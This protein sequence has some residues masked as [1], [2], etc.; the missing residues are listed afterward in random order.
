MLYLLDYIPATNNYI[1][2]IYIV[3][4]EEK[5]KFDFEMNSMFKTFENKINEQKKLYE[6]QVAQQ[7]IEY[8]Q[9]LSK[10]YEDQ[11]TKVEKIKLAQNAYNQTRRSNL[12]AIR[13]NRPATTDMTQFN[14]MVES[15]LKKYDPKKSIDNPPDLFQ[16][17]QQKQN[18]LKTKFIKKIEKIITLNPQNDDNNNDYKDVND[19]YKEDNHIIATC[20]RCSGAITAIDFE[21]N[22]S[23]SHTGNGQFEHISC[24]ASKNR[25]YIQRF[26]SSISQYSLDATG[27]CTINA[28]E[29]AIQLQM[30]RKPSIELVDEIVNLAALYKQDKHTAVGDILPAVTRYNTNLVKVDWL[31]ITV[32][33]IP[34]IIDAMVKVL[35]NESSTTNSVSAVLTKPPETIFIHMIKKGN[36]YIYDSHPRPQLNGSHFLIFNNR[37][38]VE[39][40]LQSMWP[41]QRL[42]AGFDD[43]RSQL[44]N[45][46]DVTLLQ[47]KSGAKPSKK[48]NL[49]IMGLELSKVGV[50]LEKK[51]QD[52]FGKNNDYHNGSNKNGNSQRDSKQCRFKKNQKGNCQRELKQAKVSAISLKHLAVICDYVQNCVV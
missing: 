8:K 29:A 35:Q 27:S 30:N 21:S 15:K 6:L 3:I 24:D 13:N 23:E 16:T 50:S 51:W 20:K 25:L 39:R 49:E 37:K 45:M 10:N 4:D 34:R 1:Y 43:L 28:L 44:I 46:L 14:A 2:C 12:D 7:F 9:A 33:D 47:L 5:Q 38:H 11:R 17:L 22:V 26:V 18:A 32:N 41:Y 48:P 31:Q 36:I 42:G 19:D 52:T 40:Y